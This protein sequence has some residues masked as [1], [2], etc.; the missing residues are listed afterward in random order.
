MEYI[1]GY[2]IGFFLD[3]Y[4]VCSKKQE[5]IKEIIIGIWK[6]IKFIKQQL[7]GFFYKKK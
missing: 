1:Q 7:K 3:H 2:S 5:N 4:N 6:H